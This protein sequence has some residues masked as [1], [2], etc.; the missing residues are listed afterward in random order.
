MS[1][2]K[3]ETPAWEV[4]QV[5]S[6]HIHELTPNHKAIAFELRLDQVALGSTKS[7]KVDENR[8]IDERIVE[9]EVLSENERLVMTRVSVRTLTVTDSLNVSLTFTAL[10][11]YNSIDALSQLYLLPQ[12]VIYCLMDALKSLVQ[13]L[14]GGTGASSVVDGMKLV[15]LG[16][17]VETARRVSS[18]AWY[19]HS[20][21]LSST[22][23]S[24]S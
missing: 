6:C 4:T 19:S 3:T 7:T 14:M 21:T 8:I 22:L 9:Y 1:L 5:T 18:S 16:G 20:I 15:V 23:S 10:L 12:T 13:P 24:Y 17:T 11:T 2:S